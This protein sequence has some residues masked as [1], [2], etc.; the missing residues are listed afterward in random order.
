M[1]E[2]RTEIDGHNVGVSRSDS[3]STDGWTLE[4]CDKLI[5]GISGMEQTSPD[6][7]VS[8]PD[9]RCMECVQSRA[10]A[11]SSQFDGRVLVVDATDGAAG[12]SGPA[13]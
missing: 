8:H 12:L 11:A 6:I 10:K 4:R 13:C 1:G 5:A 2:Q 3:T 7:P 9:L